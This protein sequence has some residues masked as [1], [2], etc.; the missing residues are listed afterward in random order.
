MFDEG[1]NL[2]SVLVDGILV[3]IVVIIN[4]YVDVILLLVN[5][6]VKLNVKNF[7]KGNIVFYEVV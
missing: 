6:G 5:V 4:K 3:L 2:E 1:V 7:S